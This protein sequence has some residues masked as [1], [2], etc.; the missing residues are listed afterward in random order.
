MNNKNRI[1][2]VSS[3]GGV[4][5][6]TVCVNLARAFAAAGQRVLLVDLDTTAPALDMLLGVENSVYDVKDVLLGR[7]KVEEAAVRLP[8]SPNMYLLCG[9]LDPTADLPLTNLPYA[10]DEAERSLGVSVILLNTHGPGLHAKT[11]AS[12]ATDT[13]LV[14]HVGALSLYAAEQ[15]G[16]FLRSIDAPNIRLVINQYDIERAEPPIISMIDSTGVQLIGVIPDD[17][18]MAEAQ[19]QG[20]MAK[21]GATH[22]TICAFRN[23]AHRLRGQHAPLFFRFKGIKR[24]KLIVSVK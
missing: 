8:H 3:K 5:T 11:L 1:W 20:K 19:L 12:V 14:T 9:T 23:I 7:M 4:G 16:V 22:N 21:E 6:S 13:L 18:D 15:C 24:K 17:R 10:L 2:T